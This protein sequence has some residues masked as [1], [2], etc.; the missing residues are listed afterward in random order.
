MFPSLSLGDGL[1][2]GL[3]LCVPPK[4]AWERPCRRPKTSPMA[5]N[6]NRRTKYNTSSHLSTLISSFTFLKFLYL[7]MRIRSSVSYK[8]YPATVPEYLIELFRRPLRCINT[9]SEAVSSTCSC[10]NPKLTR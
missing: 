5:L 7:S 3:A 1:A 10:P 2:L 9:N 6:L 4:I 8:D